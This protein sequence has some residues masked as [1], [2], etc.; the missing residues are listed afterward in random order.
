LLQSHIALHFL[1]ALP[2]SWKNG[3]VTGLR[4]RGRITVDI[5]WTDGKLKK[6]ILYPELDQEIEVIG[7]LLSI[8]RDGHTV[9][10]QKTDIGFRFYAEKGR[11]YC[12][13][14]QISNNM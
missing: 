12:L 14:R 5:E 6:A 8:T 11:T 3:K 2:D 13:S 10:I 9:P 4:A 7:A 1:P